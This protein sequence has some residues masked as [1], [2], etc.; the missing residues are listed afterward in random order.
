MFVTWNLM[1]MIINFHILHTYTYNLEKF[2]GLF[3]VF[4]NNLVIHNLII[5]ILLFSDPV[6][7]CILLILP[8]S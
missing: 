1:F 7:R 8:Q 5:T 4:K 2:S 6:K 3:I